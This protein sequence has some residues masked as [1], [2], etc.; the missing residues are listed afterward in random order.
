VY[1]KGTVVNAQRQSIYCSP[2]YAIRYGTPGVAAVLFPGLDDAGEKDRSADVG[3]DKLNT[4]SENNSG[5]LE[6]ERVNLH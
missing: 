3:T 1:A 2:E 4:V 5:N 6:S